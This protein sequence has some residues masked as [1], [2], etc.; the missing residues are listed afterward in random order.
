MS[1]SSDFSGVHQRM[2]EQGRLFI[3]KELEAQ[4][5]GQLNV[6]MLR[7]M[8]D[9]RYGLNRSRDWV[10]TQAMAMAEMAAVEI[11]NLG[12]MKVVKILRAGR[13]HLGARAVIAG[14]A[15]PAELD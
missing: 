1:L 13:D 8:L 6:L 14:I 11:I 9:M 2:T 12:T 5:D 3:L 7:D 15:R 10:E 4:V